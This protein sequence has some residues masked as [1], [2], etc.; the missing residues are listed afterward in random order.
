[1]VNQYQFFLDS[2][3]LFTLD[4]T[5]IEKYIILVFISFNTILCS[6]VLFSKKFSA[7]AKNINLIT[8]GTAAL[9]YAGAKAADS[10]D[11]ITSKNGESK[12]K[13]SDNNGNDNKSESNK[14][15]AGPS[16]K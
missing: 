15:G 2:F 10:Y 16:K 8:T 5:N 12:S 4:I 1:M 11:K 6:Y 14:E 9:I 7:I 3:N 13:P